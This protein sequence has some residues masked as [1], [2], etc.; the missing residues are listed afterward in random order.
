MTST[1]SC[2]NRVHWLVLV[3]AILGL[4]IPARANAG[5]VKTFAVCSDAAMSQPSTRPPLYKGY[6][7]P[8]EIISRCVWLYYRFGVSLRDVSDLEWQR[9]PVRGPGVT[10]QPRSHVPSALHSQSGRAASPG[11][12]RVSR[13]TGRRQRPSKPRHSRFLSLLAHVCRRGVRPDTVG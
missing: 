5:I 11:H 9:L 13:R 10:G 2:S 1:S 8:P 7:F 3:L 4:G 6:R 12:L